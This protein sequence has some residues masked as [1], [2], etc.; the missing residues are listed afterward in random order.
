MLPEL[1]LVALILACSLT[2]LAWSSYL[3]VK[4]AVSLVPFALAQS[5]FLIL[6]TIILIYSFA[7]DDFSVQYVANNS[8]SSLLLIYKLAAL[9][10]GHEGSLLLLITIMSLW[11]MVLT[12]YLKSSELQFANTTLIIAMSL[13]AF[14]IINLVISSNPFIRL[15]PNIPLDGADL[16]PLLQDIGMTIHPPILYIGYVGNIVG[17]SLTCAGLLNNK[18]DVGYIKLIKKFVRATWAILGVGIALG[19]WWAYYELGWGGWWFWDPVENASFMP[20]LLNAAVIHA[21][22]L[23]IRNARFLKIAQL[24]V[25]MSFALSIFGTFLVRGAAVSSVHS[26]ANSPNKG[27]F[28]LVVL[29]IIIPWSLYLLIKKE[30]YIKNIR[31]LNK[32]DMFLLANVI[33]LILAMLVVFLGTVYPLYDKKVSIGFPYYNSVFIPIISGLMLTLL[34]AIP[35][36]HKLKYFGIN[37]LISALL[38]LAILKFSFV[39]INWFAWFGLTL[40]IAV[41]I[42][43]LCSSFNYKMKFAHLGFAVVVIGVSITPMYEV[44]LDVRMGIGQHASVREYMITLEQVVK[45]TRGN[46]IAYKALF[47]I[48]KNDIKVATL[49]PEKRVF[50]ARE[51]STAETALFPGLLE[52]LSITLSNQIDNNTWA[53]RIYYKPFVR[54]IWLGAFIMALAVFSWRNKN[55]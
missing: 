46:H 11:V 1:G 13:V 10:G 12:F 2:I 27:L 25:I 33:L 20:W 24:L 44:E 3:R 54:F 43:T 34:I 51:I 38:A 17:F 53:V 50:V 9:W 16:N 47:N 48:F 36:F 26:F 7:I 52:D 37:L 5:F 40:G 18:F 41:A 21:L 45:E 22:L 30:H 49:N 55:D 29:A 14:F 4:S 32:L 8:H 15:F 35:P 19:S 28:L 31:Q 42:S 6:A 39:F 23:A